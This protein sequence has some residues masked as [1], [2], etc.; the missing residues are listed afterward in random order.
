MQSP[1][2]WIKHSTFLFCVDSM[3]RKRK[4]DI[5]TAMKRCSFEA[6]QEGFYWM[7]YPATPFKFARDFEGAVGMR[8]EDKCLTSIRNRDSAG[9]E[10]Q[11]GLC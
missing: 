11:V 8:S 9:T 6:G 7:K 10:V 4:K 1:R 2:D 3:G 5:A